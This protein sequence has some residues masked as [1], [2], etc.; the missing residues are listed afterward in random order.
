[1]TPDQF[2][3]DIKNHQLTILRD[4]GVHRHLRFKKP[5]TIDRYFDLITWP[6]H[7]C[8]TGDMG[9]YLFSRLPD[10]F[11][12]FRSGQGKINPG[13]WAEKVLAADRHG[14]IEEF[15]EDDFDRAVMR[16]LIQWLRDHRNKTTKDERRELWEEVIAEIINADSSPDGMRKQ[17]AA[18]DYYKSLAHVS[19]NDDRQMFMFVDLF[20]QRFTRYTH[21]Y[22][23]CC[24]AIVWGIQQYDKTTQAIKQEIPA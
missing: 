16:Y 5:N 22:L 14:G 11:G 18:H 4:Q 12:F 8:Y 10:M 9:S 24:H 19:R 3:D 7:L 17:I 1:M 20:D 15:D 21:H 23:W 13:Y 6:G 2:L